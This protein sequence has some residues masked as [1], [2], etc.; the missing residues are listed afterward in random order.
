MMALV[1]AEED[2]WSI[3]NSDGVLVGSFDFSKLF[4]KWK[5]LLGCQL[6]LVAEGINFCVSCGLDGSWSRWDF[7]LHV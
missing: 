1:A 5:G 4:A 3:F 6:V 7:I 2:L